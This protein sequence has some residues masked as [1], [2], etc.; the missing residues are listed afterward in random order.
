MSVPDNVPMIDIDVPRH[1]WT[2]HVGP[3]GHVYA[4]N[5]LTKRATWKL[6]LVT[7]PPPFVQFPPPVPNYHVPM[8]I[9]DRVSARHRIPRSN[10]YLCVTA[11]GN[12]FYY[13]LATKVST[14]AVPT[15]LA[16]A[17]AKLDA[18][19]TEKTSSSMVEVESMDVDPL[20][21]PAPPK[22]KS[23]ETG[24]GVVPLVAYDDSDDDD[25]DGDGD[26]GANAAQPPGVDKETEE[27]EDLEAELLR[28]E[29]D[30]ALAARLDAIVGDHDDDDEE[31]Q[32]DF[33][34]HKFSFEEKAEAF[35]TEMRDKAVDPFSAYD[36]VVDDLPDLDLTDRER[37]MLFDRY[38]A[39]EAEARAARKPVLDPRTAFMALVG[40]NRK[41]FWEEFKRKFRKDPKFYGIGRDDREREKLWKET[42]KMRPEELARV[43]KEAEQEVAATT[44][45]TMT[46]DDR[47][48]APPT[49]QLLQQRQQQRQQQR[50]A[51]EA[52]ALRARAE[53][54]HRDQA[55]T[56]R[57]AASARRRMQLDEAAA[58][59]TAVVADVARAGDDPDTVL[60]SARRDPRYAAC[61]RQG[62]A[63]P[64]M[65]AAAR[66]RLDHLRFAAERAVRDAVMAHVRPADL[67]TATTS[68]V[69]RDADWARDAA[70]A[71]GVGGA[72]AL[73]RLMDSAL[74]ARRATA[75]QAASDALTDARAL[76]EGWVADRLGDGIDDPVAIADQAR[77]IVDADP[78]WEAAAAL[79]S[80]LGG[81]LRAAVRDALRTVL[82]KLSGALTASLLPPKL[83]AEAGAN[84]TAA[85]AQPKKSAAH[86]NAEDDFVDYSI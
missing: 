31:E 39:H 79:E 46:S 61:L 13:H 56:T 25:S 5:H 71:R 9:P 21:V 68:S 17:I 30:A 55:A 37:R 65:R 10:V 11:A 54:V 42:R 44:T 1:G 58:V 57:D 20:V 36:L 24:R 50:A 72:A 35:L 8:Q 77:D 66:D 26:G 2:L 18:R 4:W 53:Q 22:P 81:L 19:L 40:D 63:V 84:D 51:A 14:W 47:P 3:T 75:V 80:E 32:G 41:L 59:W 60:A 83:S 78:R 27:E 49:S 48:A 73:E 74:I 52:E 45:T 6:P 69:L 67:A 7:P 33:E 85:T 34:I 76:L 38:C 16:D 28:L 70:L 23:I 29:A 15:E 12:R 82:E 64:A 62:L 43:V 86:H